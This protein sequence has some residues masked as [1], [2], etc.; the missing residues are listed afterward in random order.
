MNGTRQTPVPLAIKSLLL[1]HLQL[2][3]LS[4]GK[5]APPY[6]VLVQNN[7][8]IRKRHKPKAWHRADTQEVPM[9]MIAEVLM[10]RKHI[11]YQ[12]CG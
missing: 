2:P 3:H 4:N 12:L 11:S 5:Q 7:E 9:V 10:G 8:I 6:G 1:N